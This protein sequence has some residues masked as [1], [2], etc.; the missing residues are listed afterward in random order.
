VFV[1]ADHQVSVLI[2]RLFDLEVG[3]S[4]IHRYPQEI[5]RGALKRVGGLMQFHYDDETQVFTCTYKAAQK[6]PKP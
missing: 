1:V 3:D 5:M 4:I 6:G 2:R